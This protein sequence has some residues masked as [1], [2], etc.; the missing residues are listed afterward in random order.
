MYVAPNGAATNAPAKTTEAAATGECFNCRQQ[1][2]QSRECT[3]PRAAQAVWPCQQQQMWAPTPFNSMPYGWSPGPYCPQPMSFNVQLMHMQQQQQ[4]A[5]QM[6]FLMPPMAQQSMEQQH[7]HMMNIVMQ[8]HGLQN[9]EEQPVYENKSPFNYS[10]LDSRLPLPARALTVGITPI[11]C[12]TGATHQMTCQQQCTGPGHL[13]SSHTIKVANGAGITDATEGPIHWQTTANGQ[14]Y[15]V[16][17]H[18]FYS[19]TLTSNLLAPIPLMDKGFAL[20]LAPFGA[21][22][23]LTTPEGFT[24]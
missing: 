20:Q 19:N 21:S 1:G 22:A 16:K 3:A 14:T 6:A 17:D 7:M 11:T 4:P 15:V 18:C 10:S 9:G 2:H 24:I 23:T 5:A 12:D 8:Q 13:P